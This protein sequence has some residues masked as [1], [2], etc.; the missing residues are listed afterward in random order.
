MSKKDQ[1]SFAAT[2]AMI[3]PGTDAELAAKL[4]E[5][6]AAVEETGKTGKLTLS[7]TVSP[8]ETIDGAVLVND[9]IRIAKPEHPRKGSLAY[10]TSEHELSSRDPNSLS[11]FDGDLREAPVTEIRELKERD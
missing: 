7:L 2:L 4:R 3:R 6:I 10:V 11:L 9:Q 1:G 8:A 5:L